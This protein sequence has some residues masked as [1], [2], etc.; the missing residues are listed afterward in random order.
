MSNVETEVQEITAWCGQVRNEGRKV[1]AVSV[2]SK[3]ERDRLGEEADGIDREIKDMEHFKKGDPSQLHKRRAAIADKLEDFSPKPM[4]GLARNALLV[5]EKRVL[6]EIKPALVP[7]EDLRRNPAGTVGRLQRGEMSASVKD[8]IIYWRNL[9]KQIHQ[10]DDDPELCSLEPHRT[11]IIRP[12]GTST[13]MPGA[14]IPGH[15]AM[16]PAAK[17]NWPGGLGEGVNSALAQAERAERT[18]Q[19]QIEGGRKG[20]ARSKG[21]PRKKPVYSPEERERRRQRLVQV[22]AARKAK[23]DAAA[24][25]YGGAGA[26]QEG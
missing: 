15:H 11:H 2:L 3:A 7:Y 9:R 23:R 4:S 22:N 16:T 24:A 26:S 17:E 21:K 8:K 1:R 18:R 5:E 19:A 6:D 10:D 14:Q 12:D 20:A 13:F 25:A